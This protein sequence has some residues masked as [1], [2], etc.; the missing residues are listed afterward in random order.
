MNFFKN[1]KRF[2]ALFM[3]AVII[4]PG[5]Y[6]YSAEY[7]PPVTYINAPN[8]INI[9]GETLSWNPVNHALG[10]FVYVNGNRASNSLQATTFNLDSLNLIPGQHRIQVKAFGSGLESPL[11]SA[12]NFSIAS[13]NFNND[14][15]YD[16][17]NQQP[18]PS[19]PPAQESLLESG[20]QSNDNRL[21]IVD[22]EILIP[23]KP[24]SE[25][26][27]EDE[28]HLVADDEDT[29][30]TN[31]PE[32]DN[33]K[34]ENRLG[35]EDGNK[36]QN[37]TDK[38]YQETENESPEAELE[39]EEDQYEEPE[40]MISI[41]PYSA[42]TNWADLQAALANNAVNTIT[43]EGTITLGSTI[44]INRSL[45]LY[46]TG[47]L[48]IPAGISTGI[49]VASGSTL[50]INGP[51]VNHT[52]TTNITGINISSAGSLHFTSGTIQNITGTAIS[53]SG[54]LNFNGGTVTSSTISGVNN[55]G[56]F[57]LNGGTINSSGSNGVLNSSAFNFSAGTIS[58][59]QIGVT[60][61]TLSNLVM[62]G[63]TIN[64]NI[65]GIVN[66]GATTL[67][68]T[69]SI[70]NNG[71]T[72]Q[73][74]NGVLNNG[75]FNMSGGS[76]TNNTGTQ[77][78]GVS[79]NT[80]A[81]FNL[82]G[83]S[84][85]S[86]TATVRGGGVFNNFGGTFTFA[87]PAT[88]SN[89][90]APANQGANIFGAHTGNGSVEANTSFNPPSI[91]INFNLNSGHGRMYADNIL[92]Q[93]NFSIQIMQGQT[94]NDLI[95]TNRI[96][97]PHLIGQELTTAAGQ[98]R[99]AFNEWRIGNVPVN[100]TAPIT[101]GTTIMANWHPFVT[102]TFNHPGGGWSMPWGGGNR[103]VHI[104]T[105]TT[106]NNAINTVLGWSYSFNNLFVPSNP[107]GF[108][109]AHG[110]QWFSNSAS[111]NSNLNL[112]WT[113][114]AGGWWP[115]WPGWGWGSPGTGSISLTFNPRG[116][117]WPGG[118][119]G[120]RSYNIN[121]NQTIQNRFG[122]TTW[123]LNNNS[124]LTPSRSGFSFS[125][126][127]I[128][129]TSNSLTAN[130]SFN[131]SSTLNAR[132][133]PTGTTS[134][135]NF[136][137]NGGTWVS[138]GGSST[139]GQTV[140][141]NNNLANN[142]I[143]SWEAINMVPQRPGFTFNGWENTSTG[144]VFT[145]NTNVSSQ[146]VNIQ[147]RWT[148]N[149]NRS[150]TF[151]PQG[152]TWPIG[153]TSNIVRTIPNGAS[154]S[155]HTGQ[156][157]AN[158]IYTPTRNGFAFEGWYIGTTNTPFTVNTTINN[159]MTVNARWRELTISILTPPTQPGPS[160]TPI[161]TTPTLPNIPLPTIISFV[162]VLPGEWYQ[163]YVATV[164]GR[165]LFQG[166][167]ENTF[168]PN[169][170]MT[171]AMFAQVLLNLS[172]H[173]PIT[174]TA[175]FDVESGAWYAGAVNWAALNNIVEGTGYGLFSPSQEI[176]REQMAVMLLRYAEAANIQLPQANA[177]LTFTDQGEVSPWAQHAVAIM[178]ASGIV[179]GRPNGMFDPQ[180]TATRAEV[181]AIF[182]RFIGL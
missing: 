90:N 103:V 36:N 6:F 54:T 144:A 109:W 49:T 30:L 61:L 137:T 170:N 32:S 173:N 69:A 79:N 110:N 100:L 22:E 59:N 122:F 101:Q 119:S 39:T 95:S 182:A 179:T 19:L 96:S 116:G 123:D 62:N 132:W 161:P 177:N 73:P 26:T 18:A 135:I 152:G 134:T 38:D 8:G 53:N 81:T 150:I 93:G 43:I 21:P 128:G 66:N 25:H 72:A 106:L 83:G 121:S 97:V 113:N 165:G 145:L 131:S 65:T 176:T 162:D 87:Q 15:L 70:T 78:A 60:N 71:T 42:V 5:F 35:T 80:G 130:S 104:T 1:Y 164:V 143:Q 20:N 159:N 154:V 124:N 98:H 86:N 63:G 75:T 50:T 142:G 12:V 68:G 105:G 107:G 149:N 136:N 56:T 139:R 171:R 138:G 160:F 127:Y 146:T 169:L 133:H 57:N 158:F 76:V 23:N 157:L 108:A 111:V 92:R 129:T 175:F 52:G 67:S 64:G 77:G 51:T 11:S 74:G 115:G 29:L 10:Y 125:G 2:T 166:T 48:T 147:A 99:Q 85:T 141:R 153:G 117:T 181:A 31:N 112:V 126:W 4:L 178:Q 120:S 40:E 174:A 84:I 156:S 148:A 58:N 151:N 46:G 180:A 118:G 37:E 16:R 41:V 14:Q 27:Y 88:I 163:N 168:S 33:Y 172:G 55:L 44:V 13:T 155:S 114:T 140:A 102:L 7:T 94:L 9:R 167:S 89:N 47:T 82:T 91:T 45:T 28:Y 17:G 34:D 3:A 24:E